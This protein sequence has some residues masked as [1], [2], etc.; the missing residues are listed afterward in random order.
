MSAGERG[1]AGPMGERG[2]IGDHGQDGRDGHEGSDGEEGLRG[3][4]GEKGET[5]DAYSSWITRNIVRAYC[6]LGLGVMTAIGLTAYAFDQTTD[7]IERVAAEACASGN[8]RSDIQRD[9]FTESL[10]LTQSIDLQKLFGFGPEQ[11]A[12]FRRLSAES[13]ERRI[14]GLPYTDCRTGIRIHPPTTTTKGTP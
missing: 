6:I 2:K 1:P 5:G 8:L 11:E 4:R 3:L 12:D 10:R 13:A 7:R 14:Y 9:D